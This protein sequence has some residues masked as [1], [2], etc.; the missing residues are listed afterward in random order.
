MNLSEIISQADA[1]V[2]NAVSTGDKVIQLNAIN[3]DFFNVVKIPRVYQIGCV[4]TQS[5]YKIP[6][7]I[8][9]KNVDKVMVGMFQY[10]S[11]DNTD[12][13]PTQNAFYIND[14]TH[15]LTVYPA[16]YTD[17]EMFIRYHKVATSNYTSSNLSAV[18]DA[19]LEYHWTYVPAL[20]ACLAYTEDDSAK[21]GN[22]E[23]QYKNAWNVAAQNY[24]AVSNP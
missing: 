3:Q 6:D 19:P 9:Q 16:P 22:Y 5:K 24:L 11:L 2:P 8:L 4:S 17:L 10:K 21:A 18:P 20:A 15:E 12:V 7:Y 14:D 23:A 13:V 1:L